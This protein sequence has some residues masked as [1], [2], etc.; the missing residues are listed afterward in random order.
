MTSL[1]VRTLDQPAEAGRSRPDEPLLEVTGLCVDYGIGPD[2]VHAV[3]DADLVLHRGEV[4][5]LAGESGS[6]KST[7]AYATTRLLRA[8]GVIT[9]GS[10]RFHLGQDRDIDLLAADEAQLRRLRWA[11]VAVVMQSAMHALNPVM[12][13]GDQLGDVLQAH[14]PDMDR[15]AR[16]DRAVQLLD[17]V[18]ITADRLRSYPH[19]LS[20]GMRQ[21]VMI[22]MALALEPQMVIMDEPTTALDVV[23]QREILEELTALRDRLGFAVLFIT[24]DLSLLIEIA[25][26]IAIMYGGR[27]VE[28]ARA[29]AL[30]RAPRHPYT[31]GL[32][33]SFPSLHGPRVHM[34]GIAGSPPDLG[35]PPAGC[36]FHPRCGYVMERCRTE[37][38]PLRPVA[39]ADSADP[40]VAACWLQ[41]GSAPPPAELARPEP[42]PSPAPAP[43]PA[44]AWAGRH[45]GRHGRRHQGRCRMTAPG[46]APAL[47]V[48]GTPVLEARSLVKHFP[49]HRR[50]RRTQR[51]AVVHAV[52][53]VSIA[54][55]EASITA[56]VGE[57]GCG[58]S[59]LTQMLA[60]LIRPTS[61]ELLLNGSPAARRDAREYAGQV[62]MVLQDP[63]ASLNLVHTVRYHLARP[64]RIHGL[65]PDGR[66]LDDEIT[67]LLERVA[68][69]P[70]SADKYPHELSGGQ[71]Q[72]VAIA[73]A[74]AVRPRVLLAD[75]PVS[76]LDVSIRLGVLNLLA[77]LRERERLAIMYVTHDIA[78][79][80][81]LGDTIAVMYAGQIIE[82]GP[83]VTVTDQPSHPYTQLLLAAAPDPDR[84]SPTALRG[85][86]A[87]PS[88]VSPPAGC[89]FHPRCPYAMAI[90]AQQ[91]P[92]G[93]E[94]ASG[95]RQCLLAAREGRRPRYV[96][97][98]P[99]RAPGRSRRPRQA[100]RTA[101]RR[102]ERAHDAARPITRARQGHPGQE[103]E[104]RP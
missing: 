49:V 90:C 85:R 65:G 82:Q 35:N 7:F 66:S 89:R 30:F 46:A 26:S 25:D 54:V 57:S 40:R 78:S 95:A 102:K 62:Q 9:G 93:I 4:L 64:L 76:M 96:P 104:C 58:K 94:V 18:G 31:L 14:R 13:I 6:G 44:R 23:T 98:P 1:H 70:Q 12:S 8:P 87:P 91:A 39:R 103:I 71:R 32:L 84:P 56:V 38:P 77:D 88:L 43:A 5:G 99:A 47:P 24:H 37:L 17:M 42:G 73:R 45:S 72:R 16:R 48:T 80:R 100:N 50:G 3:L 68:L 97:E 101:V 52:D 10:V 34:T 22:A 59:T 67:S 15:A 20:G 63:F 36:P 75:E 61:G 21:R 2:A 51:G 79:A 92:P 41:D 74:L 11:H 29:T 86:G 83:A 81:Y 19:E 69:S 55:P 33:G 53:D 27:I 28:R 60:Q